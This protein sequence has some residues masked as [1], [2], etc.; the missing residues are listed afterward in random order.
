M[1]HVLKIAKYALLGIASLAIIGVILGGLLFTFYASTA[2]KLSEAK[3]KSTTSS[4][5]YDSDNNLIAD[6]GAEKRENVTADNIPV[7]LV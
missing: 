1:N 4:L 5:I 3:L 6:L 7:D 2:P